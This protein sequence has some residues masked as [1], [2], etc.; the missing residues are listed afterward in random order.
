MVIVN[1]ANGEKVLLRALIDQ[2]SQSAFVT[3]SVVQLLKLQKKKNIC[4]VETLSL[5]T[6]SHNYVTFLHIQP[7]FKSEFSLMS[8]AIVVQKIPSPKIDLDMTECEYKHLKNLQLA[9]PSY[10][11]SGKYDILLGAAEHA[12]II[13]SKVVKG[14]K[15]EPVAQNTELGWIISGPTKNKLKVSPITFIVEIQDKIINFF[16]ND[17]LR[18]T[19]DEHKLNDEESFCEEHFKS[20]YSRSDDGKFSV[21]LAFKDNLTKPMLGDS[22]KKALATLYQMENRFKKHPKLHNDYKNFM[23]EYLVNGHMELSTYDPESFYLPHHAVIRNESTTT[24]L[25]V[26]FNASQATTNGKSL[27]EQLA[28]GESHQSDILTILLNFRKFKFAFTADIEKM[29]RQIWISK[30]HRKYQK[31]LWRNSPDEPIKEYELKTVTYGTSI[32]PFLA[33][34]VTKQIALDCDD[35]FPDISRMILKSMYMD[36]I[37]DGAPAAD[38]MIEIYNNLKTIVLESITIKGEV[39]Y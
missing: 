27:N 21:K 26:V 12:Q 20:N 37:A 39:A 2:G 11:K 8:E 16:E 5:T 35:D 38:K 3:E 15:H 34:R 19:S 33:I 30:E 13:L 36:D 1:S 23:N 9:D 14:E 7:R 29:Y 32:A 17:D 28:I 10:M 22:R 4:N 6:D 25:R 18:E 24:K 31:I